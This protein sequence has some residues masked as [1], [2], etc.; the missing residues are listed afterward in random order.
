VTYQNAATTQRVLAISSY[1]TLDLAP[2]HRWIG[3]DVELHLLL[4]DNLIRGMATP[5]GKGLVE[6]CASVRFLKN[7]SYSD[8][9]LIEAA[10]I[11]ESKQITK[12]VCLHEYEVERCAA[13]S[14]HF[15][16][17]SLPFETAILYRDKQRMK[18]KLQGVVN[19]ARYAVVN[20]ASELI[21]A[22]GKLGFPCVLK[23]AAGASSRGTE[24]FKDFASILRYLQ[25]TPLKGKCVLEEFV[26]GPMFHV[27]GLVVRGALVF[28]SVSRYYNSCLD[29][30]TKR[31]LGTL[32]LSPDHPD[33]V[34]LL[35]RTRDVLDALEYNR[36]GAFHAE[37]WKV[38]RDY[39]FCEI[40]ARVGGGGVSNCI[41]GRYGVDLLKAHVLSQVYEEYEPPNLS[42][43]DGYTWGCLALAPRNGLLLHVEP[44]CPIKDVHRYLVRGKIGENYAANDHPTTLLQFFTRSRSE[45][46][47]LATFA[48]LQQWAHG[49]MEWCACES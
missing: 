30:R 19:I 12:L 29:Y 41:E 1:F 5:S 22:S 3:Q 26:E 7:L 45:E 47:A 49:A 44:T 37:F 13:L 17:P 20:S 43:N 18:S 25:G 32:T 33:S 38:G 42:G 16:L 28:Y 34:A 48:E 21:S 11:I 27:D 14:E 4:D 9:F 40:G 36:S 35:A 31:V 10:A 24:V 6:S 2:I 23:S 8:Q 46:D 39:V 15:G